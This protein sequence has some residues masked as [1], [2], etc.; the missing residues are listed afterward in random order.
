MD[1]TEAVICTYIFKHLLILKTN[2]INKL[3]KDVH[4]I[5]NLIKN[6]ISVTF[7][8]KN[9]N[10]NANANYNAGAENTGL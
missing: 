10:T 9:F 4:K 3:T 2:C 1:H 7:V 6:Q 5:E 8:N